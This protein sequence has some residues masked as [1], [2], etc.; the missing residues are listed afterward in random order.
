[1]TYE[2]DI[3]R[4]HTRR[5]IYLRALSPFKD[6]QVLALPVP[7]CPFR[8]WSV[9]PSRRRWSACAA[10][11]RWTASPGACR[12]APAPAGR[13]CRPPATTTGGRR[14][15]SACRP[16]AP[17]PAERSSALSTPTGRRRRRPRPGRCRRTSRVPSET[18]VCDTNQK[19]KNRKMIFDFDSFGFDGKWSLFNTVPVWLLSGRHGVTQLL[20]E[21]K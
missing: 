3:L 14:S 11:R 9:W 13:P 16:P 2:W 17:R 12:G 5:F 21:W 8:C 18:S 15:G 10:G 19:K 6:I 1:M 7:V 4:Y 20:I